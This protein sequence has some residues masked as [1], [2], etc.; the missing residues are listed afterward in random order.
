MPLAGFSL[1]WR[2]RLSPYMAV[3]GG[4]VVFATLLVIV[5][6]AIV[7]P[8]RERIDE[9]RDRQRRLSARSF[10][11]IEN[12]SRPV[13]ALTSVPGLLPYALSGG[14]LGMTWGAARIIETS[15]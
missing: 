7:Q 9:E 12:L 13:L 14:L 4:A 2:Y 1:V 3:G 6:V 11:S 15:V 8:F 10:L 5:F